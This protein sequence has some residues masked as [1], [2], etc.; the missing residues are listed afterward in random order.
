MPESKEKPPRVPKTQK[1][2]FA[3][4]VDVASGLEAS[5]YGIK[6]QLDDKGNYFANI[7]EARAKVEL[8]REGKA[9]TKTVKK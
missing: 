5:A 8:K 1:L 6:L 4:F 2:Y 7:P 9:F 3:H